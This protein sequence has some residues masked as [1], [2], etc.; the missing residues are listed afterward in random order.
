MSV[1]AVNIYGTR[2]HGTWDKLEFVPKR[3][4]VQMQK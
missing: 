1:I 3:E 2:K 4:E